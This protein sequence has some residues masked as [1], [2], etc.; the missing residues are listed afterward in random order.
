MLELL[1]A[2]DLGV[3]SAAEEELQR[4]VV[5]WQGTFERKGVKVNAKTTE[6]I[7]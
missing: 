6:V 1:Y 4:R 7:V 3:L 5:E 2:D